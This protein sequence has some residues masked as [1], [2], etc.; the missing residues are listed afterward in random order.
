L[1]KPIIAGNWKMNKT[2]VQAHEL[3]LGLAKGLQD[4]TWAE[5]VLCPPATS[6]STVA[7][8]IADTEIGLGA[9][10]LFWEEEGAY[11]GEI[12]PVM[13]QD[14][15]CTYVIIGHSE[16]RGYFHETD[17]EVAKK[18]RAAL[19]HHLS[20][21]VC[22]GESLS[23]REEN[24]VEEVIGTQ[25]KAA[26]APVSPEEASSVIIAYEPIWAIGTGR[27]S[28]AE[29]AQAVISFI[30][31]TAGEVLG[32]NAASQIRIQYGG[33]VKPGNINQ[34]MAQPDI[35]GALVGGASLS[36]E[37]FSQLLDSAIVEGK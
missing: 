35:D 32:E 29:D 36:V 22:V 2:T 18:V 6:I 10:N 37:Q 20:P 5:V 34:Y 11:T 23:Q 12:S 3:A 25:V 26:L 31:K 28:S 14:L 27:S 13:L 7:A 21:I 24:K 17:Q 16:R 9:Q 33:S 8:A 1:R 4:Y 19:D 30:R 15:G